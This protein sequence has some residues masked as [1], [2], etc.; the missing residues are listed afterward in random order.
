MR[1]WSKTPVATR[2]GAGVLVFGLALAATTCK[3][4]DL[5][6]PGHAGTLILNP[7]SVLD[8][9]PAGSTALHNYSVSIAGGQ[10]SE[11]VDWSVQVAQAS[12]WI[13]L[14]ATSGH[15]PGTFSAGLDPTGLATG[16][17]TDTLIFT[18][19]GPAS[20]PVSVPVQFKITGCTVTAVT[21]TVTV[22]D[23]LTGADCAAPNRAGHFGQLYRFNAAANDSITIRLTSTAF[24]GFLLLDTLPG[25]PPIAQNDACSAGVQDPCLRYLRI[26]H[27]GSYTVEATSAAAGA[28]GQFQIAITKPRPPA[29]P[30]TLRQL[31]SDLVT[32]V[33]VNGVL[34]V[35]TM[36]LRGT[37]TDPDADTV[38]MEVEVEPVGTAFTNVANGGSSFVASGSTANASVAGLNDDTGY[39]WQARTVDNTGRASAWLS[40]GGN[41]ES[42]AD[43]RV[44][45]PQP[46]SAPTATTQLKTDGTTA[47]GV[48]ATTDEATVL[49]QAS[50]ND[51]D[52]ADVVRLEVE[53]QPLGTAFTN[54]ATGASPAVARGSVATAT[55]GGLADNMA[56]HWQFRAVDETGRA[57]AWTSFGGNAESAADLRVAL[58]PSH[59]T[60]TVQPGTTAAGASLAPAITVAAQD[61]AGNTL[62]SFGGTVAIAI[63]NN[64]SGGT[65][66]GTASAAASAGVATFAGLSIDKSGAGYTLIATSGTLTSISNAFTVSAASAT[67]LVFTA[68]PTSATAGAAFSPVVQVTVRDGLGN[69]ATGFNGTVTMAL[70]SGP[71]GGALVG[72]TSVTA[73]AGVATFTGLS[74]SKSGSGY[75][76]TA[77]A[78]GVTG[79]TSSS[80]AVSAAGASRLSLTNALPGSGASGVALGTQPVLQIQD[81]FGNPVAQSG[82]VVTAS[83]ASGPAGSVAGA[84]ATTDNAG[85]A[86]FSGLAINGPSGGYTLSFAANSLTSVTSG[87]ITLG[88]GAPVSLIFAT[89]PSSGAQ[90]GVAFATQ[91]RLQIADAAGNAVS[92]VGA[93]VTAALAAPAG[94]ATLG[95][96][97]TATTGST[98]LAIFT[99]LSISGPSGA[100]Q[101]VFTSGSLTGATSGTITIGSGVPATIALVTGSGQSAVA[102][103]AVAAGPTVLVTDG[104]NNPV[105]GV[106]VTFAVT[107]GGG[108]V[109]PTPV[110]TDAAGH[111][112][113]QWTLGTTVGANTMTAAGTSVSLAGSPVQ[114][115]ATGTTGAA[116][117]F[118]KSAGDLQTGP[119]SAPLGS[120]LEVLVTD[121]HGNPIQGAAITWGTTS[122]SVGAPN[123]TNAQGKATT[124]W[125]LGG[126]A[127]QQSATATTTIAGNPVSVT[128]TA[129][130]NVGGAAHTTLNGGDAQTDT[131]GATL[132]TPLSVLV[133][134]ANNNPVPGV[135]VTW[136]VTTSGIP[137]VVGQVNP[138]SSVTNASGIASTNW[139]LGTSTSTGQ[140][141]RATAAGSVN[142]IATAT[143]GT[144]NAGQSLLSAS[145]GTISASTGSVTATV[146]VTAK[147]AFGNLV[148]GKTV[149]IAGSGNGNTLVQPSS[150]TSASG[151]ATGTFASTLAGSHSVSATAAGIAV[152]Q[153][154]TVQVN[155]ASASNLNFIA[156]PT[157]P[158]PAGSA[159]SSPQVEILDAFSNRV[160]S[161]TS[162]VMLAIGNNPSGG[163][164][165]GATSVGA[166]AGVATFAGLSIDNAGTGYTLAASSSGLSGATSG[167]FDITSVSQTIT[168]AQPA[169]PVAFGASFT[170]APTATSGLTVTV[171]PSG[172]CS[173]SAGTVTMTSG[174]VDCVLTASQA[175]NAGYLPAANVVRTVTAAKASQAITFGQPTSPAAFGSTFSVAPTSSSGLTVTVTP[176]GGCSIGA[177][178]VT[179]TSGSVD[180]VLTASQA[181]DANFAPAANVIR[182]VTAAK[183]AQTITFAQPTS[184]VTVGTTFPVAPT[185][186]S[187]LTV[188]VTPSGGCTI[189][190]GTVTM[191]SGS[192][193]CALTASQAGDA[194]F[195]A[196]T[197]VVRTVTAAKAAQTITFAQPTSPA[198]FGTS[199]GV[200]PTSSS[201]LNVTVTPTGGC[202]ISSGT[203]TMTSGSVDCVLTASQAGDANFA[204]ATDVVRTVTAAKAGQTI[205]FAPPTSP[206]TF[207]TSFSVAPTSSSG[208]SVTVTPSGGCTIG[209]GT[210]TMTSGSVDCVLTASQAG[211]ANFSAATDVVRTVTAA[212]AGQ[213]ITFAQPTSPAAFGSTFP[214]APTG[215]SGLAVAVTPSGGCTISSGT[216]TMTSGSVDCVLTA[217]QAG[218]ANYAPATNVVRT[219][220]AAAAAQTI[221]FVQPTSPAAFGSTFPVAPTSSSNLT[222]TVAPSGGCSI[223]AGTVTMTSGS[224]DCVLTASQAGDA[225]FSAATDVIRTVTAAKAAQ[226]ITFAQPT[227]PAAFGTTFLVAPTSNS[228]LA[229]GVTPS[230][231]C[232]IAGGTVTMTSGSV[233]CVLTASQAGDANNAAATDV[234]RTVTAAKAAQTI[235]FAQPT[236][237]AVFGTSFSV[238]PTSSS[239]LT[240]TVTP[241]GGCS[242]S[243]GTVTMTSGSVDCVL[244]GSQAGDANYAAAADVVHTVTAAKASQA[245]L[246]IIVPAND[247]IGA[248][249]LLAST[250]G[251]SGAGAVT[252]SSTTTA[253]CT[254]DVNSGAI[255]TLTLGTCTLTA[256][257]AGDADHLQTTSAGGSFQVLPGAG[258][259]LMFS[260]QPSTPQTAGLPFSA[261]VTALD[262]HG[263]VATGFTAS[264][265]VAGSGFAL[266]GTTSA[267]AS[268]GVAMFTNLVAQAAGTNYHLAASSSGLTGANS[269]DFNVNA[270][271]PDTVRVFSGDNQTATVNTAVATAPSVIVVDAF[272]N[273]VQGATVTFTV[274]SGGGSV[275]GNP[276]TADNSGIA[277]LGSWTLGVLTGANTLDASVNGHSATF[278]A[279][280]TPGS[281]SVDSSVVSV[282]SGTVSLTVTNTTTITLQ[283]KDAFDNNLTAGGLSVLFSGTGSVPSSFTI[284]GT[285]DNGD[286]TY[287]A[288]FT[289]AL[290]DTVTIDATIGGITVTRTP[291]PTVT[292]TP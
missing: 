133:T 156:A 259:Q 243:A 18:I 190:G 225:N 27:S 189:S 19:T 107:G 92:Q 103:T 290:P 65:L 210:V 175:G 165:S 196:A 69:V 209:G 83:I 155:P 202:S 84:S 91:P 160:T 235:T 4:G 13:K 64:P 253:V 222:V 125:T 26:P 82:V 114:F 275:S 199:F 89:A 157:G 285:T 58:A 200:A 139:T 234:V 52:P 265:S 169:Q 240:V 120:P 204:A 182:T 117:S 80:F 292:V 174:S 39:H 119:V 16:T 101:I 211:D 239:G 268:S 116:V 191:T 22:N 54:A 286:G 50:V 248:A 274:T 53:V 249:G 34:D 55:I 62:A 42:A 111:A 136:S 263:N 181:G 282:G 206:A 171:T 213:T 218:D 194:N 166:L 11:V 264:V 144:V 67:T 232:S 90:S 51:P 25:Q 129:T 121:T 188:T 31:L 128:F 205:T 23:S 141:A 203:V 41:A 137:S 36:N 247:S 35:A 24:D 68:L 78:G 269:N 283:A 145:I 105:Q 57:S 246:T 220:T 29:A 113:T 102:G 61:A 288:T 163:T 7:L 97:L 6:N 256:T 112:S 115:T 244:T 227:S 59:L 289:G 77:S 197:D 254:I 66:S 15:T 96:T 70:G 193:D 168:F 214:V 8:S 9:A 224:V 267:S 212:K 180:C 12:P 63:S 231:G 164:L 252:F 172:G 237:P 81:A 279:T 140:G 250:S 40:F 47:I 176:S 223:S 198:G 245:T 177:G 167:S 38:R 173:I 98:G 185:S 280:A 195:A 76:L 262:A 46:P 110:T 238:A 126:T 260:A 48:G 162:S 208:L 278:H 228:G 134:D 151:V 272:G 108:S 106:S 215:S 161:A 94:T 28:T 122:G 178:T 33:A 143:P 221:T 183:A 152:T 217:S 159:L 124:T 187:G 154:A 20:T 255:A 192:V 72:T 86:T 95:G 3:L 123:T 258:S 142:F 99:N 251:G 179:M 266:S 132:V 230:G 17:Y 32:P 233:D 276:A 270:G 216:V 281:A 118:T 37:L 147:D 104:S 93:T 79:A 229:V 71:S 5:V 44:A 153:Q 291:K 271:A 109:T 10:A 148:P 100:Y 242:I 2:V 207:G 73:V 146:T 236:S 261:T 1:H 49:F 241:S 186:S 170:V 219:V 226:N 85:V 43:F 60:F 21:P 158:T 150:P 201:S 45:I 273:R 30:D 56:Y 257:K 287:T 284:S 149:T 75:T 131:V 87:T 277:T 135:T 74:L 14:P 184:P 127:G 130:A 138:T 88:A